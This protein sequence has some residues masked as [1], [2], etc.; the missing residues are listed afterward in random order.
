[1]G[2]TK[3]H[4]F[5]IGAYMNPRIGETCE[6]SSQCT[7]ERGALRAPAYLAYTGH[8]SIRETCT[9]KESIKPL[10]LYAGKLNAAKISGAR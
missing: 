7:P 4:H 9:E 3:V 8:N 10:V 1:M 5:L 2:T 6:R